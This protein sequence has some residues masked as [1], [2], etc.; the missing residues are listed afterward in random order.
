MTERDSASRRYGPAPRRGDGAFAGGFSLVE[1]LVALAVA[2][3][4]L[5]VA[6]PSFSQLTLDLRLSALH[7]ALAGDLRLARLEAIKRGGA[8]TVC[9]RG[10]A[11]SCGTN[12]S[13]GW[14][15]LAESGGGTLGVVDTGERLIRSRTGGGASRHVSASAVL[16]PAPLAERSHIVFD[17]R[18]RA[19][20]TLGTVVFCDER[21]AERARALVVNGA[22]GV[23]RAQA[24]ADGSTVADAFGDAVGCAA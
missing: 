20:W 2:A 22:G 9:A 19:D 16:R 5:G 4:L 23:R 17:G 14:H 11:T 3:I 10:D 7:N 15:V 13:A 6:A 1:L 12:W 24:P 8:V 18:G 21:G